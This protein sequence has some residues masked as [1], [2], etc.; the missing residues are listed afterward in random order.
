MYSTPLEILKELSSIKNYQHEVIMLEKL[1]LEKDLKSFW[2]Y[3]RYLKIRRTFKNETITVSS[4]PAESYDPLKSTH[5]PPTHY[6]SSYHNSTRGLIT[7][8]DSQWFKSSVGEHGATIYSGEDYDDATDTYH[9]YVETYFNI[10]D[11]VVS[12]THLRYL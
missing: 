6:Y 10:A 5:S 1:L 9:S 11:Q 7:T 12:C 2:R 8:S 4:G 3:V